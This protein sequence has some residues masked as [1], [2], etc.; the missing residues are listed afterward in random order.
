MTEPR[1]SFSVIVMD[2][3]RERKRSLKV[4][5]QQEAELERIESIK[6]RYQSELIILSIVCKYC[7]PL[8]YLRRCQKNV[9]L[10]E[11]KRQSPS[12]RQKEAEAMAAK[13][14]AETEK[15]RED[16]RSRV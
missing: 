13:R 10:K 4:R 9:K 11:S 5:E 2:L 8:S 3:R 12:L 14:Q 1:N 6:K 15:E 16:R 7:V